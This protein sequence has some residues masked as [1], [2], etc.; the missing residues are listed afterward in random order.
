[1][2]EDIAEVVHAVIRTG[3]DLKE[4]LARGEPVEHEQA[5]QEVLRY[6]DDARLNESG[7]DELGVRFALACW[8]DEILIDDSPWGQRWSED[9]CLELK[10]YQTRLRAHKFWDPGVKRAEARPGGDALEVYYLCYLLGFR[11]DYDGRTGDLR[12]WAERVQ[13]QVIRTYAEEPPQLDKSTPESNVPLLYGREK[14]QTMLRVWGG[15][16]LLLAFA[17]GF[18][19]IYKIGQG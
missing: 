2:R 7:R 10:L 1:M 4:R 18:L 13:P 16:L 9:Y 8:I 12:A 15:V 6:L 17:L 3:F 14:F 5:R 11:G 19:L